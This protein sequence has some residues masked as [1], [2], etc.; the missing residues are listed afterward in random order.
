MASVHGIVVDFFRAYPYVVV[1]Y[2]L[3][4]VV[5]PLSAVVIPFF[6]G[7]LLGVVHRHKGNAFE[8]ARPTMYTI[9]VLFMIS[10]IMQTF[11]NVLDNIIA[12]RFY[13]FVRTAM[14]EYVFLAYQRDFRHPRVS[15]IIYK[16]GNL[17]WTCIQI[18]YKMRVIL[19][20]TVVTLIGV[21]IYMFLQ[22]WAVGVM[23]LLVLVAFVAIY[24]SMIASCMKKMQHA[25]Q[26]GDDIMEEIGDAMENLITVY[27]TASTP[28][29]LDRLRDKQKVLQ[30]KLYRAHLC[31]T[32]FR[33][34]FTLLM[35]SYFVM[36]V[37]MLLYMVNAG[38]MGVGAL[39]STIMILMRSQSILLSVSRQVIPMVFELAVLAKMQKFLDNLPR[40]LDPPTMT[41]LLTP[42]QLKSATIEIANARVYGTTDA[43]AD[44]T[45]KQA[46]LTMDA[47]RIAPGDRVLVTGHIGSGKSTLLKALTGLLPYKGSVLINGTQVRDM[48]REVLSRYMV[49]VPQS[50]VLFNRTVYENVSYGNGA[51]RDRVLGLITRFQISFAPLDLVVGKGGNRLS[52]GQ[53]Q[54]VYLLR[55]L[56]D[57]TPIVLMDEPTSNMD[58][59]WKSMIMGI[60][61]E[62]MQDRTV[63]LISH[64][65]GM[66]KTSVKF[67]RQIIFAKG[68]IAEDKIISR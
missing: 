31:S 17:P 9:I 43:T 34:L 29:E 47:L 63:L 51:S 37:F 58:P 19:L 62:I 7:K 46:I 54:T 61:Q 26:M 68:A 5:Y 60:L 41:R 32:G 57:A 40:D 23:F 22:H 52:G 45:A 42:A 55:C 20:P 15:E 8:A 35:E 44:G 64:D 56:L 53:R 27:T 66:T 18:I 36:G 39:A 24:V 14:V 12:P 30:E 49:Y 13:T 4:L 28:A 67:N 11:L 6:V 59:L 2:L 25:D 1:L 21:L 3:F 16:I 33:F 48:S 38:H 10:L 65:D 50:P